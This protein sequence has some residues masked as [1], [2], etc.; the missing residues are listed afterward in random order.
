MKRPQKSG[1]ARIDTAIQQT[2]KDLPRVLDCGR[3][4]IA[5]T[6]EFTVAHS[7][8]EVPDFYI[9]NPWSDIRIYATETNQS[10]WTDRIIVLTS[11]GAG[12]ATVKVGKH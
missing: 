9:A 6:S 5:G 12:T 7:L 2:V 4:D 1:D 3:V 8:G 10:K 11:S